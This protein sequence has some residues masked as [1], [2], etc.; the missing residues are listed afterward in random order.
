METK[1]DGPK[2][3]AVEAAREWVAYLTPLRTRGPGGSKDEDT[4]AVAELIGF[5]RR[6]LL[7]LSVW[8][9]VGA[10]IGAGA[11]YLIRPTFRATI[12]LAIAK[13]DDSSAAGMISGQLGGLAGLVGMNLGGAAD[14]QEYI[15]LLKSR[16]LARRFIEERNLMPIIFENMWN[17]EEQRWEVSDEADIPTIEDAVEA[18]DTRIRHVAEDRRT[19][20]VSVDFELR[21]R[22]LAASWANALVDRVNQLARDRVIAEARAS[23]DYLG[24]ELRGTESVEVQR[25]IFSLI[26]T[27]KKREM[28][29][30]VRKEYAFRVIDPATVP[31]ED[32]F[33]RPKRPLFAFAG[34]IMLMISVLAFA[35]WREKRRPRA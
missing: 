27:Q 7:L 25:T 4:V 31:D 3:T 16:D 28:V 18:F 34:G 22:E 30:S 24:A 12:V 23:L 21:D 10:A 14:E 2:G 13:S 29:A 26:E 6:H 1:D 11:S 33:V 20:L 19:G 17:E 35:A 5:V 32:R 9:G 15:A 8:L